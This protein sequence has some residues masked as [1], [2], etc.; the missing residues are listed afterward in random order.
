MSASTTSAAPPSTRAHTT[1]TTPYGDIRIKL[2]SRDGEIFNAA[3]EF[4]DCRTAATTHNVPVK[5][6]LQ[7]AL[8]LYL[9]QQ[10]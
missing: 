4:E 9:G 10:Q 8:T 3:P 1:V 6:V 2:G 5:T 7:S